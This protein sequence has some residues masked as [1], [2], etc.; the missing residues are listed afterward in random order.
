MDAGK[1]D[2]IKAAIRKIHAGEELGAVKSD[3]KAAVKGLTEAEIA[4][5]EEEV[6]R[7]GASVEDVRQLCGAHLEVFREAMAEKK[8]DV[9]FWHPLHI[10]EEEHIDLANK[11][12]LMKRQVH[13]ILHGEG[14][15]D[16]AKAKLAGLVSWLGKADFNFLKQENAFFP[17]LE[18]H[19]IVQPPKIM[20]A[21][22]DSLRAIQKRL[23]GL[24]A[25]GIGPSNIAAMRDAVLEY[26]GLLLEHIM[27]ERTILFPAGLSLLSEAEWKAMRREFDEIG[28]FA[29]FPMPF[30]AAEA[31]QA[32][33]GA[34]PAVGDVGKGAPDAASGSVDVDTGYLSREE[35]VAM[36]KAL[37][38]D[39]SFVDAEDKVKYFND[40]KDRIFVRTKSVVG[41]SVQNC[42]PPKSVDVVTGILDD[43]RAGRKS[44]ED[45]WLRLGE[46]FVLIRYFAVRADDGRYL[47]ALEVSQ[48]IAPLKALEGEKRLR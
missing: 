26:E 25:A 43:F 38:V 39:I 13:A 33:G 36:L 21:E 11:L 19:G 1:R 40:T 35:L 24:V 6:M 45:F 32:A 12:G 7:E 29:F 14:D 9:P 3:F 23:A 20:W 22:H 27:K 44:Q 10:Q 17:V 34:G 2:A 37:P 18:R 30:A 15:A 31:A 42:H 5:V 47:G 8:L 48:D 46:K 28:Y 16:D 4:E 41:R